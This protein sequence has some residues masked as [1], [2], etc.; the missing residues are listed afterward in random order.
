MSARES[1]LVL[2][3]CFGLKRSRASSNLL[4]RDAIF[5]S[6]TSSFVCTSFVRILD[7]IKEERIYPYQSIIVLEIFL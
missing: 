3:L 5:T 7:C 2:D 4:A 1:R 6:D